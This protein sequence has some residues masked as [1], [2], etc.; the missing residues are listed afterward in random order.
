MKVQIIG[1]AVGPTAATVILKVGKEEVRVQLPTHKT[2]TLRELKRA[3]A[4]NT[5]TMGIMNS[6]LAIL[7]RMLLEEIEI[8]IK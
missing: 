5:K 1:Y 4:S 6:R 7:K 3:I 8:D 2:L